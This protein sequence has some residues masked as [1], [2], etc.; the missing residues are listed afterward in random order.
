MN[1][2]RPQI[3]KAMLK[4]KS[5]AGGIT[6]PDFKLYYKAVVIKTAWYQHKNRHTDQQNRIENTEMNPQLYGQ[7]T[8]NK[9]GKN[10][11]WEKDSLFNK[12]C[13]ENW[14]AV[15]K[16]MKLDQFL[17]PHTNI[18][19]NSKWMKDLNVRQESIEI[20]EENT[21]RKLLDIGH[22]NFFLGMTPEAR[23]RKAKIIYTVFKLS[24]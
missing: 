24:F 11:P 19:S 2:K 9:G 21:R 13:W 3:A 1:H 5:K 15:C 7:I 20:L 8:F 6:I 22:S 23:E 17:T 14:T 16:R 4:K 18:N 10:M 12:W